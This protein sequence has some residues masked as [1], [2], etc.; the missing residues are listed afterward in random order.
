[1]NY[2]LNY[3]QMYRKVLQCTPLRQSEYTGECQSCSFR[4]PSKYILMKLCVLVLKIVHF[5][6]TKPNESTTK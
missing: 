2:I 4:K 3:A 5:L 6:E 1:M